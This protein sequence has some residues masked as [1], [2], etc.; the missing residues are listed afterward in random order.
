[1]VQVE[2]GL[3]VT[4][5]CDPE[6]PNLVTLRLWGGDVKQEVLWSNQEATS[7]PQ[8]VVLEN[9]KVT[10]LLT[11]C[12][13]VENDHVYAVCFHSVGNVQLRKK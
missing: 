8:R 10:G 11:F 6:K 9:L 5:K 12:V 3:A 13:R 7:A 4:L 2:G 1:M